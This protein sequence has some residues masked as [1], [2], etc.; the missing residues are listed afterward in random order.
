MAKSE[1]IA[2]LD[3]GS[4][5][6]TCV[7]AEQELDSDTIK[8]IS[9]SKVECKGLKGGVVVDIKDTANA[10]AEAVEKAEEEAQRTADF[11]L[12]GVRGSHL[13]SLNSHGAYN[14]ARTDKEINAED[15]Q[16]AVENAK[17]IPISSNMKIL[18]VTPQSFSIDRQRGVPNPEGMEGSLLEVDVHVVTASTSH[19]NNLEKAVNKAGFKV[20]ESIFNLVALGECVLTTEEKELGVVLM[21]LGGE[22]TSIAIYADGCIQFSKEIPFGCDLITRD[23]AY[24]LHTSRSAARNIKEKYGIATSAFLMEDEEIPVPSLDGQNTHNVTSSFLLDI[25]QPRVEELFEKVREE[26]QKTKYADIP[27]V[28]VITGGG[29]LL[30]GIP[31]IACQAM[32][33]REVRRAGVLRELVTADEKFFNPAY[34]GAISLIVYPNLVFNQDFDVVPRKKGSILSKMKELFTAVD[35][36]GKD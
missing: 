6:V 17:A 35:I 12:M 19:L 5:N 9:G 10:V 29:S 8:I 22:V 30:K 7:L 21:D 1:I 33:I 26:I 36:F 18:K 11:V 25:I 32:G 14:I 20:E 16:F 15:V 34:T 31:E 28:G 27:G 24:G 13:Q 3:M 23:I 4:G 2:G